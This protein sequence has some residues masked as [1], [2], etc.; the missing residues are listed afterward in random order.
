MKVA[1]SS[2]GPT[3][4]DQVD[5]RFGR[6]PY[7][8]IINPDTMEFEALPNTNAELGGGAGIQSAQLV[9]EKGASTV[10]TGR[11][12]P[13][14]VQ[15]F[16]QGGVQVVTDVSGTVR[17]AVQQFATGTL[18]PSSAA[19]AAERFSGVTGLGMG[20]G[21]GGSRGGMGGGGRGMGGGGRGMGGGR[22]NR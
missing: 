6:C 5:P 13:N 18:K 21:M 14:A 22:R 9:A 12:G 15:V 8:L 1:V 4:D 3:L 7:L 20:R 17:Q 11:C 16:G 2:T 19:Q 10:L